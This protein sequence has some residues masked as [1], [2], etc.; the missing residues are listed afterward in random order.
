M[1]NNNDTKC[2]TIFERLREDHDRHRRLLDILCKSSGGDSE[3]RKELWPKLRDD[4]MDHAKAEERAFYAPLLANKSS[5]NLSS[6]SIKEHEEM[7]VLIDE[8][9]AM[10]FSHTHWLQ[11][12]KNLQHFVEHHEDEEEKE[13]FPVAGR[14]LTDQEKQDMV[15]AFNQAKRVEANS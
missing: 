1:S 15:S 10:D 11:K 7:E 12:V 14:V 2:D 6:H 9:D 13:V 3:A 4:L 8:I 5:Q